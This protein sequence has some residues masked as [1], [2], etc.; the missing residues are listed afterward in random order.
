MQEEINVTRARVDHSLQHS[1][2]VIGILFGL[3]RRCLGASFLPLF[4]RPELK[5]N[6][7]AKKI[8]RVCDLLDSEIGLYVYNKV[9][10]AK[11]H[12]RGTNEENM[13]MLV[14]LCRRDSEENENGSNIMVLGRSYS[15]EK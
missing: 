12:G 6:P 3:R 13:V 5:N 9:A 7:L 15:P 8:C 1:E 4:L 2:R 14:V 11:I 10:D